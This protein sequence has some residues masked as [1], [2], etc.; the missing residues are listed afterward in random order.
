MSD[1]YPEFYLRKRQREQ[2]YRR[3]TIVVVGLLV[4]VGL[5]AVVG[6]IAFNAFAT[7]RTPPGATPQ[8]A[9]QQQQLQTAEQLAS[10]SVPADVLENTAQQPSVDL[11]SVSYSESFPQVDVKLEG[12]QAKAE[13]DSSELPAEA[14]ATDQPPAVGRE[15][16]AAAGSDTTTAPVT[17]ATDNTAEAPKPSEQDSRV[18][19]VTPSDDDARRKADQLK[20]QE[21]AKR[22]AQ[23]REAQKKAD[24]KK[25]RELAKQKQADEDK[26]AAKLADA[27]PRDDS[28][29]APASKSAGYS[30]TVYGGT[31]LSSEE[32][33][34]DRAK[35]GALG[36]SGNVIHVA[37]D[38][39]L[40]VGRLDDK[41]S[42]AALSG[43]LRGSGLGSAFVTRKAK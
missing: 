8:L 28:V 17:D 26:A 19:S 3:W 37:G 29:R 20:R 11:S 32:A 4:F 34:K 36:L 42:A 35:L 41:D 9:E 18:G 6:Y 43:K 25:K 40:L 27:K 2:S 24:E 13:G 33:E 5:G 21:Q 16:E 39:L 31:Y 38:Y 30:Y 10:S 1:Y 14:D 12:A 15:G 23:K 22:E 7:R